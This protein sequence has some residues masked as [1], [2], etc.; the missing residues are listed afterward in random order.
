MGSPKGL[1]TIGGKTFLRHIVDEIQQAG[2]HDIVIVLGAESEKIQKSLPWFH[3]RIVVNQNWKDGQLSSIITGLNS[4]QFETCDGLLVCPVD[5]PLISRNLFSQLVQIFQENT[6]KIIVP[7]FRG[8][9]GHPMIFPSR[10]FGEIKNASLD[11]GAREVVRNH[12]DDIVEMMT[13]ENGVVINID[14]PSDYDLHIL[15]YNQ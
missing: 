5:H 1:L 2:I 6:S 10:F 8:R 4:I 14:T 7:V 9:R 3:G 11:I 13:E 12:P 15:K